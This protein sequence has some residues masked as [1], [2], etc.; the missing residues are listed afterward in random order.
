MCAGVMAHIGHFDNL[1]LPPPSIR[2]SPPV[3]LI[4]SQLTRL[5]HHHNHAPHPAPPTFTP[6]HIYTLRLTGK[7]SVHA[8][9]FQSF[10]IAS[11]L[12]FQS[13]R[14]TVTD[15]E[16]H[17]H[18]VSFILLLYALLNVVCRVS[19]DDTICAMFKKLYTRDQSMDWT[20]FTSVFDCTL[21]I[22]RLILNKVQYAPWFSSRLRRY[23][24]YLLTYLLT[25]NGFSW[26][27]QWLS[28]YFFDQP[29]SLIRAVD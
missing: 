20:D 12:S 21:N 2:P 10:V 3:L 24:N 25:Y 6:I 27:A 11:C 28:L 17:S 15:V 14:L 4:T 18:K 26:T 29:L 23:I 19:A 22:S 5:E 16:L 9:V 8:D 13:S 1:P 7:S